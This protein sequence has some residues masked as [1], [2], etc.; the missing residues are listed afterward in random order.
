MKTEIITNRL[1]IYGDKCSPFS[2]VETHYHLVIAENEH[3]DLFVNLLINN[4]LPYLEKRFADC[5]T[6]HHDSERWLNDQI[7]YPNPF[8]GIL[9][10]EMWRR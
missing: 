8:T 5:E 3:N 6:R 10:H 4:E 9:L 1:S 2:G 7:G